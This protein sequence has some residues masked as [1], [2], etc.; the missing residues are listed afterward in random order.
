MT[1]KSTADAGRGLTVNMAELNEIYARADYYD[2]A[3]A[4]DIEREVKFIH[5][6]Q[7]HR[8]GREL[9]SL[10]EIACGPGA[11]LNRRFRG[12]RCVSGAV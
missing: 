6:L 11:P 2:I 1:P 4:R 3:F 10:L 8:T 7:Q 9:E 12:I 5:D